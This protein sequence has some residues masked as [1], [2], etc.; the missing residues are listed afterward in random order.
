MPIEYW[1]INALRPHEEI[2]Q[3]RLGEMVEKIQANGF[4]HK[5]IL[6]DA[7]SKT[8]LDGHHKWAAARVL[9]LVHI[10][11]LAVDYLRDER[12]TVAVWP[13]CGKDSITKEEVVGMALDDRLFAAKTSKHEVAFEIPN[14]EVP[15]SQ[16]RSQ[17]HTP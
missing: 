2:H 4:F 9:S 13:S 6:V 17:D 5:P 10:P 8:I 7:V 12:I 16:L 3:S 1:E 14:I 15:L 11:V